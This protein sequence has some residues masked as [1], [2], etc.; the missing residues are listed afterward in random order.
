MS[1][2][3]SARNS[4]GVIAG[5]SQGVACL[6]PGGRDNFVIPGPI[7]QGA[8]G[9]AMAPDMQGRACW[10]ARPVNP[11]VL[12]VFLFFSN[13]LGCL[14]SIVVSVILTV[15]IVLLMRSCGG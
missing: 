15:A 14:G 7:T 6:R 5:W 2:W 4:S 8:T 3:P 9:P 12:R 10:P 11:G 1:L 13:R